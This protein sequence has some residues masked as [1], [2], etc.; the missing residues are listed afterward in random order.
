[1]E[2]RGISPQPLFV[3]GD[4]EGIGGILRDVIRTRVAYLAT[5]PEQ[6]ARA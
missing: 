1:M 4:P 3:M 5:K 2:Y 6:R